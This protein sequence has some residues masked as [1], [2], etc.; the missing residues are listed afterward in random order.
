M[1][2]KY[3]ELEIKDSQ[4]RINQHLNNIN[5]L[6][7]QIIKLNTCTEIYIASIHLIKC[8]TDLTRDRAYLIELEKQRRGE[9]NEQ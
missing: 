7:S 3:I 9:H 8:I 4:E 2:N 6:I 1:N 5:T